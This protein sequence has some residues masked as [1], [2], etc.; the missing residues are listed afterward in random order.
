MIEI[1][2]TMHGNLRRFLPQGQSST[3][4][5]VP[6]GATLRHVIEMMHAQ[7]DVW[8]VAINGT[9][10]PVYATVTAGDAIDLYEQ[11]EGG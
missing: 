6:R 2:V 4:L 1:S 7:D 5:R 9:A 3:T 10:A 8:L 11:L